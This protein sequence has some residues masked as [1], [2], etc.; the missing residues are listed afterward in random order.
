MFSRVTTWQM[1]G[2]V[3]LTVHFAV[4][5]KWCAQCDDVKLRIPR[6][7]RTNNVHSPHI[8]NAHVSMTK[9]VLER[10]WTVCRNEDRVLQLT[11][12]R[13]VSFTTLAV[14]LRRTGINWLRGEGAV[15]DCTP[16]RPSFQLSSTLLSLRRRSSL[17]AVL[18]RT[19]HYRSRNSDHNQSTNWATLAEGQ[20]GG[21]SPP[22][23]HMRKKYNFHC[24]T[25]AQ[26]YARPEN[27]PE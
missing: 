5:P 11:A 10:R 22:F 26:P 14:I 20:K 27:R 25:L 18:V 6:E 19:S 23:L 15:F 21:S 2:K 17:V 16:P 7:M 1:K 13:I 3:C 24:T 4:E 8:L 9:M 12:D